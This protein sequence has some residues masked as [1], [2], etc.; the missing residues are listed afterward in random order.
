[1]IIFG[2]LQQALTLIHITAEVQNIVIGSLLLISVLVPNGAE[3]VRRLQSRL[4]RRV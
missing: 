1:V 3:L 2:A 4:R